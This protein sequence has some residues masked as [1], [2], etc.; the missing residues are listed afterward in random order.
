MNKIKRLLNELCPKGVE[1]KALQ[2]VCDLR[3]GERITTAMMSDKF[4]FPVMGGGEKPTGYYSNYNFQNVVTIARA[5]SAGF[6]SLQKNKFWA[7]DVCFIASAK[8]EVDI[9][10]VF[11]FFK[12]P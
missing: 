5:G 8:S 1:F 12:K 3:A 7:T 4:E 2:D 11:Y 10:Y 9:K 6:V